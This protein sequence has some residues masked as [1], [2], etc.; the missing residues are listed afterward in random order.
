MTTIFSSLCLNE[1][2]LGNRLR[3][4]RDIYSSLEKDNFSGCDSKPESWGRSE[5]H[6][7]LPLLGF[8]R[9]PPPVHGTLEYMDMVDLSKLLKLHLQW[10]TWPR[11]P[12]PPSSRTGNDRVAWV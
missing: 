6:D 11:C 10:W 4:F 12:L 3:Q 7:S 5:E 2:G 1:F 8:S 9:Q